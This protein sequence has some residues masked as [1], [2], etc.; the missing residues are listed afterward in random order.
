LVALCHSCAFTGKL[1]VL[2][3][4]SEPPKQS[5]SFA[6]SRQ[7]DYSAMEQERRA[8]LA[9]IQAAGAPD[10]EAAVRAAARGLNSSA[11]PPSDLVL[12]AQVPSRLDAGDQVLGEGGIANGFGAQAS[13]AAAFKQLTIT[14][15]LH[16]TSAAALQVGSSYY[17]QAS[18]CRW[19]LPGGLQTCRCASGQGAQR[20]SACRLQHKLMST[21]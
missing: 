13:N 3:L 2:Y 17:S 6:N 16:N 20:K 15:L 8:L 5:I 12:K 4:G 19:W 14:L 9:T 18:C 21:S 7:V 10:I 1:S 11:G